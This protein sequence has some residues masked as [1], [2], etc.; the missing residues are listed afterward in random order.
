MSVLDVCCILTQTLEASSKR[1]LFHMIMINLSSEFS[2]ISSQ[3]RIQRKKINS[4]VCL[5]RESNGN[6]RKEVKS[7]FFAL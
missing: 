6:K 5:Y 4:E 2:M 1:N 3:M 7:D